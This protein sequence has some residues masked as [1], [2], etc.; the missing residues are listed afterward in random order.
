MVQGVDHILMW[1]NF[2]VSE[3]CVET[4]VD[5]NREGSAIDGNR[6]DVVGHRVEPPVF[7]QNRQSKTMKQSS[8]LSDHAWIG[9]CLQ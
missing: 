8:F 3:Q 4:E 7:A 2:D 1:N 5:G 6:N 9:V